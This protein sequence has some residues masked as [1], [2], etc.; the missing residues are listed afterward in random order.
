M[1]RARFYPEIEPGLSLYFAKAALDEILDLACFEIYVKEEIDTQLP[2]HSIRREV[3]SQT[4]TLA[5]QFFI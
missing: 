4:L 1:K 5:S 3:F 2:A